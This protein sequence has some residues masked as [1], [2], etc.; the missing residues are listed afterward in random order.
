MLDEPL[1][2]PQHTFDTIVGQDLV[3][4]FLLR[5]WAQGKLPHS[6]M[7]V[8]PSGVGKKS[9]MFALAKKLVA[10]HLDPGSP[11]AEKALGK[12]SRSTHPDVLVIEPKSASG[13]ILKDQVEEMHDRAHYAPLESRVRIIIIHPIEAMNL[14]ASNKLLKLLEEPPPALHI[15]I[16]CRQV[17]L[18][19][20]TIKSRC[21]LLRCPPVEFEPLCRWL[22]EQTGC[23]RR[24]A[25][26]A[27]Q[28]SAGRPGLARD[29]LTGDEEEKRRRI[30]SELGFYHREGY[31][32]IFR[33]GRNLI[34]HAGGAQAA[35]ASLLL[36][37][38]DLLVAKLTAESGRENEKGIGAAE[39]RLLIN[40]NLVDEIVEAAARYTPEGVALAIE[41]ILE[42]QDDTFQ[43]M[44]D[45]DLLLEVLLTEI[46]V[47]LKT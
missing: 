16:G 33:V 41:K 10:S 2:A 20:S 40:R 21:A 19:L 37:Y 11:E 31:A 36:W 43:A 22:M 12:V 6:L 29:L 23:L 26:A 32:T 42:R 34:N 45:G 27:A 28:L 35:V 47:A 3:K 38:R 15:L 30:C 4:K 39:E 13:Q 46:G 18:T 8:G 17:H 1:T 25:E 9:L 24:R 5:A 7:F 44:V 14:V